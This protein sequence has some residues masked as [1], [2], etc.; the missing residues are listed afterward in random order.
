M[1]I[2]IDNAAGF[3]FGVLQTIEKATNSINSNQNKNI[4]VLG[5]I[6]H[7]PAEIK[8]LNNIGLHTISVNDLAKLNTNSIIV[9]IRAHGEPPMIYKLLEELNIKYI[10][11]TCPLV[12]QLQTKIIDYHTSNYQIIIFG[13]V[14]HPEVIGLCGVCNG[15]CLVGLEL[16]DF[17]G[18]ID[19]SKKSVLFSQTTMSADKFIS[20]YNDLLLNFTDNNLLKIENTI[21]KFMI[22]REEKLKIFAANNDLIIFV[23][24][25]NSSNGRVLYSKCRAVNN[26]TI[27]I[28]NMDE[29]DLSVILEY[30]NVGITGA[31]STPMWYLKEVREYIKRNI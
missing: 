14:D 24:G 31:T 28:E 27:F 8:R 15:E 5:E 30:T 11:A 23:A 18:K 17:E 22:S 26:N 9:I 19:Y 10:D 4:Y 21:C 20:I 6:I 16:E 3:C 13:K 12:K 1:N 29:L 7:N 25:K 2:N